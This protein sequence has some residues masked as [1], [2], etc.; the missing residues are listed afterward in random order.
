[1]PVLHLSAAGVPTGWIITALY[2]SSY[3]I[4]VNAA[5]SWHERQ[6]TAEAVLE[7][8]RGEVKRSEMYWKPEH[9]AKQYPDRPILLQAPGYKL[10]KDVIEIAIEHMTRTLR[11]L[12][13]LIPQE[14]WERR[15]PASKLISDRFNEWHAASAAAGRGNVAWEPKWAMFFE[16][17]EGWVPAYQLSDDL[18]GVVPTDPAAD[19][20]T[21]GYRWPNEAAAD[22]VR[23][24]MN[25][26]FTFEEAQI[27][28]M[29]EPVDE[30][31]FQPPR[32]TV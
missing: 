26:G 7:I 3:G 23:R 19:D 16:A 11:G 9:G 20:V 24:A 28:Q 12:N 18:L 5:A 1:M 21:G 8:E 29:R 31:E 27:L 15:Y 6:G 17:P 13:F 32:A 22:N 4:A 30:M 2:N 14:E 10:D 25:S